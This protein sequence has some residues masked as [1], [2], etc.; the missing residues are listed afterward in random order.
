MSAPPAAAAPSGVVTFLFTDV[1]GSTR[2]WE[3]DAQAMRAA[4]VVHD[5][6]LRTAVEAYDGFL[7][8]H[9]GDGF[10]AAFASPMSAVYAA[11]DA[12]RELGLPVRMGLATGEAELRDGDYFGT[13]L[14]R[15]ARVMAAGHGGQILLADSTAGLLS[16]VDLVDLGPRRLRDLPTPVQVFQVQAEGLQTD[17]PALRALDTSPG[18]LRPAATSFIGRESEVAEVQA[19]VKAHRLVTLTGVG[20]VGKTRLALEVAARLVDEYPDG[21]WFFELAAVT[22]PAAIPD[23]VAAVLGITQQPGKSV[24]ESVAAALE[25]R[26]R[27]LVFD[28]CEHVRDAAADLVEAILAQSATVRIVATSREGLGVADEQLWLV[29]SLD[30]GAGI[31]SAAVNLF[32]ERACSVASRFSMGSSDEGGAVVEI[33]RRLDGI[34][35]AI[36]LAASRMASMTPIE[37]RDRLDQRFRLL[38]GSRRGLARHQ[39]LRHAVAWSYDHLDDAEKPLLERCSV[40][41]GGFDLQSACAVMDSDD[42]FA[43]LDLLDALVRKSLLVADR[44]S[45]RTRF[46]MLE[47]IRQFAEEQL[48]A[49]GQATAVRAAHARYFAGCEAD[50]MSLWDGPR[51]REAYAWF[52]AE[53]ANLRTAF[54][55]ATDQGDL[56]TAATIATY[57]GLLGVMVVNYEPI[58]WAEELIEPAPSITLGSRSC[59]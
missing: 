28:N 2:R 21:V 32:V 27:L 35:L 44:S 1:E 13:V 59:M 4:L 17:F 39:T 41:A 56:D 24:S 30:V 55:W 51:Q 14:N 40:F 34:P 53:L 8:S 10:V 29:P 47:T 36:E 7:F 12:Q 48:V 38:I 45:G 33:C 42:D 50:I 23:A 43:T 18:N 49:G 5:K 54:R 20:G 6:V 22:D 57:A 31:E 15:A 3:A 19:T 9:T 46:S 16:G 11:I 25:G 37:V 26:V 52:T 58:A